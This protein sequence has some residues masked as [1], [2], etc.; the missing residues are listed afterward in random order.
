MVQRVTI[1][2][3]QHDLTD[4]EIL[5]GLNL[6]LIGDSIAVD[7]TDDFYE[8]FPNSVSDTRNRDGFTSLGKQVLDSLH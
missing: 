7:V 3:V 4:D 5:E 8:M 1:P 6:L 2:S